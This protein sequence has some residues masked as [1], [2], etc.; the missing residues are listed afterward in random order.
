MT[1]STIAAL[2]VL[3][4][5]ACAR[6]ASERVAAREDS[7]FGAL[8]AR[9]QEVMGVDQYTSEHVFE[10]LPDGGRIVLD[11]ADSSDRAAIETIRG[12]MREIA[13]A[14]T[15]GDFTAPFLVHDREVPGTSLMSERARAIRYE[16]RDRP[17][18]AEVRLATS[19]SAAVRAIH[20]FLDFQRRDH[21]ASG[22]ERHAGR[23]SS[24]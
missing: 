11:R 23:D 14:F 6:G 3:T 21:R 1:R 17:R 22:H 10:S 15:H 20:E 9:G 4:S 5:V 19:D 8:Q 18:G 12:H 7:A 2:I 16:V 24:D 13:F